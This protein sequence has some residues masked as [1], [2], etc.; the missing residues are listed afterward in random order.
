MRRHDFLRQEL[1]ARL[2]KRG[3]AIWGYLLDVA[4]IMVFRD[5]Y[6]AI[7]GKNPPFHIRILV[8]IAFSV[9]AALI[10]MHT[11]NV[12]ELNTYETIDENGDDNS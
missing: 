5:V 3:T 2:K 6:G 10:T 9:I 8:A 11:T 4:W 1:N 12:N 7:V